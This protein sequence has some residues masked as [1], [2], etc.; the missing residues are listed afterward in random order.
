MR[1]L[2]AVDLR[3]GSRLQ[4]RQRERSVAGTDQPRHLQAEMLEHPANLAV[5]AFAEAHLD[6]AIAPGPALE[7]GVDR[8]VAH[9][10]NGDAFRQILELG[11][12]DRAERS[13]AVVADDAGARQL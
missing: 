1:E 5:L 3:D 4:P 9:A 11:L 6:P 10:L 7:V 13:G 8:A 2:V 12:G